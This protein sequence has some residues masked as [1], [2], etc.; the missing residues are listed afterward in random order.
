MKLP[1]SMWT[2]PIK[3]ILKQK[4]ELPQLLKSKK[5]R[6]KTKILEHAKK[7]GRQQGLLQQQQQPQMNPQMAYMG[8]RPG[9]NMPMPNARMAAQQG[10]LR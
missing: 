9:G 6:K 7:L 5:W 2:Y 1:Y 3:R 4:R 10:L 8:Q